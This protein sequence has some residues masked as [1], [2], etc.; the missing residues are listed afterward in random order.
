M[1]ACNVGVDDVG[2]EVDNDEDGDDEGLLVEED[3][4]EEE[5]GW[6]WRCENALVAEG[7]DADMVD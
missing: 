7:P 3:G 2:G 6:R 1:W 4:V 5:E